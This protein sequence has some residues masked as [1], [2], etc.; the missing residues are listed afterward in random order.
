MCGI[1]GWVAYDQD[2]RG[3]SQRAAL[4][5]MTATM[6][7]RG[8]DA[9]GQWVSHR[10]AL[11]HR[12]LAVIDLP[13]G[14]QPMTVSD[15]DRTLAAITFSG[16]IYNYRDL[17]AELHGMGHRFRTSSDTEV[18]L[19]AYLQWGPAFTT[20]LNGMFALAVWDL[21]TQELLL[22]RDRMG[23]KP[24]YYCQVGESLLFASEPKALLAHPD[25]T[26][27]VD[28][29]G[30]REL[31][32]LAKTP[33]HGVYTGMHEV[34]PG[35]ALTF[36][37][38]GI[39]TCRYW[40]L[41]A[42]EH[43]DDLDTTIAT[44]RGL[45][46]QT[47]AQQSNADV[48]LGALLSGGLDSS[49][50][51]ALAARHTAEPLRSF[52]V[53]FDNQARDFT[54]D[55]MH[56]DCDAPFVRAV[57]EHVKTDHTDI[58]VAPGGLMNAANRLTALSARD[59]PSGLG[60]FDISALLLFQATRQHLTVALSGEGADEL[61]G[62]Y[63]WCHDPKTVQADT[64]P[65]RAAID[66]YAQVGFGDAPMATRLLD[67]TSSAPWTCPPTGPTATARPWP[68]SRTWTPPTPSNTGCG[69]SS[70]CT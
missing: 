26:P 40:S 67:P 9:E 21:R 64:F 24:L 3:S 60:D 34:P 65:W 8:P 14:S 69:K 62:G 31:L 70:T 56:V 63:F 52:S 18:A 48:P 33:G 54:P 16:E 17:R 11:G 12:R 1:T 37:R 29:D 61:F 19:T 45:L 7:R 2:L 59:L 22:V 25:I 39:S 30:L 41:Q 28:A 4:A 20:R 53:A 49:V 27:A 44:V 5:A 32:S 23:I 38:R 58:T 50:I 42:R 66:V 57:A 36:N 47:L 15:N 55:L 35:H 6:D 46:E 43:T 10:A 68:P 13:G 51:T